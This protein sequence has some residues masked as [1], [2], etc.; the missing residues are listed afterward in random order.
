MKHVALDFQFVHEQ[1]LSK[2]LRVYHVYTSY[3]LADSFTKALPRKSI[4][5]HQDKIGLCDRSAI[6]WGHDRTKSIN[7]TPT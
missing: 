6:L 1:V 2:Q 3:Q 7:N 4:L 5:S